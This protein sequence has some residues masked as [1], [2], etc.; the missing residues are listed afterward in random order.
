MG[1]VRPHLIL[2]GSRRAAAPGGR[3]SWCHPVR[4][5]GWH[6]VG[7][8]PGRGYASGPSM[9]LQ[10][11][12]D[13]VGAGSES[14]V[15]ALHR[16]S[17]SWRYRE[18]RVACRRVA[19]GWDQTPVA[20]AA[21][22]RPD[23]HVPISTACRTS[24]A[25]RAGMAVES[26]AGSRLAP[27]SWRRLTRFVLLAVLPALITLA[28]GGYFVAR[29]IAGADFTGGVLDGTTRLLEG[30]EPYEPAYVAKILHASQAGKDA[31]PIETPGYPPHVLV[32]VA[33]FALIGA[34][35]AG[36]LA[37]VLGGIS[38]VVALRAVGVSDWRCYGALALSPISLQGAL[39]AN[40]TI[41]LVPAVALAWR[42]RSSGRRLAIVLGIALSIKPL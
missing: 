2:K 33:P 13:R 35:L 15:C 26:F 29:G 20:G 1:W 28:L 27:G 10:T 41:F 9:P 16:T 12:S 32:V 6:G 8:D 22:S 7:S 18:R 19:V 40:P 3:R 11:T 31:A 25:S 36:I 14:Q 34:T 23:L 17:T 39:L 4:G 5:A 37:M 42:W 24:F 21:R 30:H 38:I